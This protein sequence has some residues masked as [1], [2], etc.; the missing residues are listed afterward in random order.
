M[1][2]RRDQKTLERKYLIE[3]QTL[4]M[5]RYTEPEPEQKVLLHRLRLTLPA[6]PPPR[7]GNLTET[8]PTEALRM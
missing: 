3:G 8:F 6:Q 4:V 7:I 1:E 5:P 2:R